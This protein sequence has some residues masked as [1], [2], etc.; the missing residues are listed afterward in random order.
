VLIVAIAIRDDVPAI[1]E[2][3]RARVDGFVTVD[4]SADDLVAAIERIVAG[5]LLC[6]PRVA[7]ELFRGMSS[8]NERDG[9]PSS[10]G[11]LLTIRE[12]QVLSCLAHGRSN[13]E[14]AASL[15]IAEATVKS[16]VHHVLEKLQVSSRAQA[17]ARATD[18]SNGLGS[19][20]ETKVRRPAR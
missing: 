3:A 6:S 10:N 18:H 2:C 8:R 15:Y 14:I 17:I 13:K 11:V 7:A 1:V 9:V 12:Q 20:I 19:L 5:E 16:H 4:A